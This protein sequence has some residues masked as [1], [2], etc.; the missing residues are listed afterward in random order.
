ELCLLAPMRGFGG[1]PLVALVDPLRVRPEA[2]ARLAREAG[3]ALTTSSH[4]VRG[5]ALR[6]LA[7]TSYRAAT[8]PERSVEIANQ[9]EDWMLRLGAPFAAAAR[10]RER[11]GGARQDG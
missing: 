7:L 8:E 5:E 6:L 4:W 10:L 11:S 9:Y 2:L 1:R 3:G